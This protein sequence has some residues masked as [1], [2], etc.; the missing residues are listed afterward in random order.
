[1][2]ALASSAPVPTRG[3]IVAHLQKKVSASRLTLFLQ[4]RLKFFFRY[5]AGIVK[6]KTAALHVGS[7]VH[8]VLKA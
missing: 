4:C 8:A 1:M 7:A 5:V 3:E 6:A 2:I